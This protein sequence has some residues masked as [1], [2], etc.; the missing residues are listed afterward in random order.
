MSSLLKLSLLAGVIAAAG[1]DAIH[2]S[3]VSAVETP[4]S[5]LD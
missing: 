4:T 1:G 2:V 5:T 3:G